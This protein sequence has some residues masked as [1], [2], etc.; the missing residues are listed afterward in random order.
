MPKGGASMVARK[1]RSA[2][3]ARQQLRG[4]ALPACGE[5]IAAG[6][7]TAHGGSSAGFAELEEELEV[8]LSELIRP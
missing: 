6:L 7:S 4:V 1:T 3:A 8:R 2:S 5:G